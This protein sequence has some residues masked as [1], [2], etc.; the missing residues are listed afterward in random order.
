MEKGERL[1]RSRMEDKISHTTKVSSVRVHDIAA[2]RAA[3]AALQQEGLPVS[4]EENA[5]CRLWSQN[6][7]MP[8]VVKVNNASGRN[9]FDVGFEKAADGKGYIPVFDY[10]GNWIGEV[11]GQGFNVA[12]TNEER[13]LANIGKLMQAYSVQALQNE[14]YRQGCSVTLTRKGDDYVMIAQQ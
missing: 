11:L 12:K 10:H 4:L 3:V 14:A 8:Y 13:V 7:K 2:L 6:P 1:G 9:R 5:P